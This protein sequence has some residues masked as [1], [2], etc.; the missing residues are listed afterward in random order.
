MI[1]AIVPTKIPMWFGHDFLIF[2]LPKL[3]RCEFWS[4]LHAARADFDMA[5]GSIDL[6]IEGAGVGSLYARTARR[7]AERSW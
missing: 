5:L 7:L 6:K 2:H 4:M 3:D 1:V